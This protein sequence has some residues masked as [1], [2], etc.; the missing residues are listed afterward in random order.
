MNGVIRTIKERRSVR[1]Y[2]DKPIDKK[3]LEEII[4]CAR[5]APSAMNI[6]PWKFLVVTER[7]KL[8]S[9]SGHLQYGDFIGEAAACV[10]ILGNKDVKR[11]VEDC[12]IASENV[13]LAAKSFGIGSC[14]VA[15]LG[16]NADKVRGL[17]QVPDEYEIV[18]FI[19]LGYFEKNPEPHDKKSL[20][21]VMVWE[22]F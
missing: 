3:V 22:E 8:E 7:G 13:M 12:C 10:V 16:K 4:D 19:S 18:C 11:Y 2:T 1:K 5:L 9:I 21:E 6:Q 20:D 14:Y 15:A 17:L